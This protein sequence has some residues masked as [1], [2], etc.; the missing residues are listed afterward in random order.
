MVSLIGRFAQLPC[1]IMACLGVLFNSNTAYSQTIITTHRYNVHDGNY[2][3]GAIVSVPVGSGEETHEWS[4]TEDP[5][6]FCPAPHCS[7]HPNPFPMG[8]VIGLPHVHVR[9]NLPKV[10]IGF[11]DGNYIGVNVNETTINAFY[12]AMYAG[13]SPEGSV[14]NKLNCHGFACG[15]GTWIEGLGGVKVADYETAPRPIN[16]GDVVF[17]GGAHTLLVTGASG[18]LVLQTKEKFRASRIYRND[19]TCGLYGVPQ[20]P[21]PTKIGGISIVGGDVQRPVP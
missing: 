20:T 18:D 13:Y 9:H 19:Y 17:F 4:Q 3:S 1:L 7:R 16:M 11:Q 2:R 14:D 5:A 10:G 15:Y 12:D 8:R 6:L 21:D